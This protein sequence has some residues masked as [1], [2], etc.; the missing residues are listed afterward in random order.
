MGRGGREIG[1][2]THKEETSYSETLIN[3]KKKERGRRM[4]MAKERGGDRPESMSRSRGR[5]SKKV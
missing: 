1:G 3:V 4:L 2:V 5:G